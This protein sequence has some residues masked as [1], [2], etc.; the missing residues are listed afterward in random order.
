MQSTAIDYSD[1][2]VI[3]RLSG[4]LQEYNETTTK[5]YETCRVLDSLEQD[6]LHKVTPSNSNIPCQL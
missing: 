5:T 3:F 1:Q 4:N 2:Q 6:I